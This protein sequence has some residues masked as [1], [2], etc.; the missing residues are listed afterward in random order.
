MAEMEV[1]LSFVLN[2]IDTA[3]TDVQSRQRCDSGGLLSSS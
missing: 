3:H 2:K 1:Q